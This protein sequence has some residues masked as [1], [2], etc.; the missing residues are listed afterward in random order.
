MKLFVAGPVNKDKYAAEIYKGDEIGHRETEFEDLFKSVKDKLYKIYRINKEE[1]DIA[2]IGGSGTCANETLLSS[3]V[4]PTMVISNGAFGER[5][6][7]ILDIH[8]QIVV[9]AKFQ[10]GKEID[11]NYVE[12]L[13][14]N[15]YVSNVCMVHME[16]S[17]GMLNPVNE[18]A[19][20]CKKYNRTFIVDAV[21]SLG[22]ERLDM[23]NIDFC[24]TNTNKGL[25]ASPVLGIV[26]CRRSKIKDLVRRSLYLD[27]GA[28][29]KY[30]KF[31]QTP[32]TPQIPLFDILD[33]ALTGILEEGLENR[34]ER[35]R[36]NAKLM[37]EGL[38][39]LG[40]KFYLKSGYSNIMT[41]VL[42]K[43]FKRLHDELKKKG[44]IVYA[45]KNEL[46]GKVMHIANIGT[47]NK[48]DVTKFLEVLKEI[49]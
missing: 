20:L 43:N 41:N 26:A 21:S 23:K 28:Y 14:K 30:G 19:K 24:V 49:K 36:Q 44:Y 40:F 10:W 18:V 2:I 32:F 25:G 15:C 1:F 7:K 31:N 35:Y 17:T 48:E 38:K 6:I 4:G 42:T 39:K 22:A 3:L 8:E 37:R 27:L 45:G 16:T 11:L 46:N 34:F 9:E 47:I 33:K 29:L 13:M 12:K 5:L